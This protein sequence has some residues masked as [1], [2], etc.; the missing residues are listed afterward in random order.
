MPP[1]LFLFV[2]TIEKVIRLWTVL[3]TKISV[4]VLKIRPF[5]RKCFFFHGKIYPKLGINKEWG[6]ITKV[7]NKENLPNIVPVVAENSGR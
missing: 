6:H 3:K 5:F 2:K 1:P 4:V 7:N